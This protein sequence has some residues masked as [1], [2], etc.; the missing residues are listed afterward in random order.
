MRN[1]LDVIFITTSIRKTKSP[2]SHFIVS[3]DFNQV[4][5][6]QVMPEYHQHISCP[7]RGPNI[8]DHCYTTIKDAYLSIS[9][10]YVGKSDH[11]TVF[12]LPAYKQKP[13]Q[14][15]SSQN[16]I[17]CWSEAAEFHLRACLDLLDWSGK[18]RRVCYHH[19]GLH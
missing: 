13:K 18:P 11:S 16:E 7:T 1:A 5:F 3:G 9:R 12:L 6:K 17:Q 15:N 2:E 4:N 14:E 19:H 10:P 8:L